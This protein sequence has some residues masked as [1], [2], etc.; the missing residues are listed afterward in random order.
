[1]DV[2]QSVLQSVLRGVLR[3]TTSIASPLL[4]YPRI[5]IIGP[6]TAEHNFIGAAGTNYNVTA[7]ASGPI[8]WSLA[9]SR[10]AQCLVLPESGSNLLTGDNQAISGATQGGYPGQITALNTRFASLPVNQRIVYYEPGRNDVQ[11]GVSVSTYKSFIARDVA[12]FRAFG[13][14]KIL[15]GLIW[16]KPTAYGATWASGGTS[17][18]RSDEINAWIVSTYSDAPDVIIVDFPAYVTDPESPDGDP[19][20]G[21]TRTADW[22]HLTSLG[23]YLLSKAIDDALEACCA[24]QA[25]PVASAANLVP[26]FSGTGGT[27][28]SVTGSVYTGWSAALTLNTSAT[29][30]ASGVTHS[31]K[32]YQRFDISNTSSVPTTGAQLELSK[33]TPLPVPA[34]NKVGLRC[35]VKIPATN[36]PYSLFFLLGTAGGSGVTAASRSYIFAGVTDASVATVL[37]P[38]D[39]FTLAGKFPGTEPLDLWLESPNYV[40]AAS[41]GSNIGVAMRVIVGP[42]APTD[43]MQI[44]I[45]E[46]QTFLWPI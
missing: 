33:S 4:N 46:I 21:T 9:K 20:P 8:T 10:R 27:K 26:E 45:G 3:D 35:R 1:M 17:R 7:A 24:P 2:T 42:G 19:Y 36:V 5:G 6:S 18:S 37:T 13:Y 41:A 40:Q 34:S 25:Y 12:A 28:T 23:G 11:S 22:T 39:A 43:T 14:A 16:K 38:G 31:D 30:I 32:P 44:D 29:V 15:I